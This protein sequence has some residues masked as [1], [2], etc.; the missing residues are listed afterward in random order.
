MSFLS[1]TSSGSSDFELAPEMT[2]ILKHVAA[3]RA[4]RIEEPSALLA[5]DDSCGSRSKLTLNTNPDEYNVCQ[6]TI[7]P[8]PDRHVGIL[9]QSICS[10]C[11]YFDY[12]TAKSY[13]LLRWSLER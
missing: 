10:G 5:Y 8:F 4:F 11:I 2:V 13:I 1:L 6:T 12:I 9:Y 7:I 3:R